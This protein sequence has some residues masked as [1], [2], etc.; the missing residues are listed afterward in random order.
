[1][2]IQPATLTALCV[3]MYD[4]QPCH[5]REVTFDPHCLD[6][7]GTKAETDAIA[8]DWVIISG[9]AALVCL[10]IAT[11]NALFSQG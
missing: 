4:Q 9:F 3:A 8:P 2:T 11:V 5:R 7:I 1:M 10:L 6:D